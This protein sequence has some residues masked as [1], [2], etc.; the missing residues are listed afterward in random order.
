M[1]KITYLTYTLS[2]LIWI[3]VVIILFKFV[4]DRQIASL[5]AG[6]GFLFLPAVLLMKE[7]K[8]KQQRSMLVIFCSL[9]FLIFFAGPIFLLRVLNW[10]T[11]FEKIEFFGI[12]PSVLHK[13]SNI[14]YLLLVAVVVFECAK[15]WINKKRQ[16]LS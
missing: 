6:L 1:K 11:A 10:N 7:F 4:E 15:E 12:S 8:A 2:L 16:R 3:P 9:Q 14:S 13:Y 5:I